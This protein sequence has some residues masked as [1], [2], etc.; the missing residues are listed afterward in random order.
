MSVERS[1]FEYRVHTLMELAGAEEGAGELERAIG[2][3]RA[4]GRNSFRL[5]RQLVRVRQGMRHFR[6]AH[7]G[8]GQRRVET[9]ETEEA[10][11]MR[12]AEEEMEAGKRGFRRR[13]AKPSQGAAREDG[14]EPAEKV[15]AGEIEDNGVTTRPRPETGALSEV[16]QASATEVG[17]EEGR[18][19]DCPGADGAEPPGADPG[20][21]E[22]STESELSPGSA[23]RGD[24]AMGEAGPATEAADEEE[25]PVTAVWNA[26][27]QRAVEEMVRQAM[28]KRETAPP[29]REASEEERIE[30]VE[31]RLQL[32]EERARTNRDGG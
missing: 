11:E 18:G 15:D 24:E 1:Q 28:A 23:P 7:R 26:R 16:P 9:E 30:A 5:E 21:A 4:L 19:A 10:R 3:A 2:K 12:Q 8:V 22:I 31:M 13:S 32:L 20:E 14:V 17:R 25:E 6:L 29:R 27:T